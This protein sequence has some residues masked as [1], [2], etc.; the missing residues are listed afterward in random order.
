MSRLGLFCLTIID[1]TWYYCRMQYKE[2][3][4]GLIIALLIVAGFAFREKIFRSA[5]EIPQEN[6]GA[7]SADNAQ[8]QGNGPSATGTPKNQSADAY[9]G[10]PLDEV[11]FSPDALQAMSS[12][13]RD[14]LS[15][16]IRKYA[17]MA[18]ENPEYGA[19]WL[20]VAVL[21]KTIGD[22]EGSRDIWLYVTVVRPAEA[23]AFLNLGDLYTNYL[24]DYPKAEKYYLGAIKADPKVAMGYLGLS[25]LY[26]FFYKEKVGQAQQI[27]KQG[28]AA[29]PS[30]ANLQK[31]LSRLH[32]RE[33][34]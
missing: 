7:E 13:H 27:L 6:K 28:I 32:E 30:D 3:F 20:Q 22:Y 34:K 25:D 9:R 8:N 12:A 1:W 2:I 11:R 24:K 10:Q 33:A 18:K 5:L 29:N 14:Q 17:K 26:I 23:T 15:A 21:K 16:D 31:A 4:I 19:A